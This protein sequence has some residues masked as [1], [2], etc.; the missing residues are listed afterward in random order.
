MQIDATWEIFASGS[1]IVPVSIVAAAPSAPA[2]VTWLTI[3]IRIVFASAFAGGQ[4]KFWSIARPAD[5]D[6]YP[7]RAPGISWALVASS[8]R[9]VRLVAEAASVAAWRHAR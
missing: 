8:W 6:T 1:L 7:S 9:R 4:V 3:R 2:L 5:I